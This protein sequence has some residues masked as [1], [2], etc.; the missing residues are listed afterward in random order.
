M[1]MGSKSIYTTIVCNENLLHHKRSDILYVCPHLT[2]H[3]DYCNASPISGFTRQMYY[4]T[5]SDSRCTF[6]LL[7]E[8]D[9]GEMLQFED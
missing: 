1:A 7:D 8:A 9:M 2:R 4:I 3:D 6:Y 5:E